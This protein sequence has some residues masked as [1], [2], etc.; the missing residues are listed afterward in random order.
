MKII[1]DCK[2]AIFEVG[3]Y[4]VILVATTVYSMLHGG[5]GMK[6][7]YMYPEVEDI[8]NK[9][10]YGDLR[11]LGTRITIPVN[12]GKEVSLLY[13]CNYPTSKQSY[14]D[15]EALEHCLMTANAEFKG[16]KVMCD[17]LGATKFNGND[18]KEKCLELIG[19][20]LTDVDLTVYD[21][22]QFSGTEE[23]RRAKK[24][25]ND[26]KKSDPDKFKRFNLTPEQLTVK[27]YARSSDADIK[28]EKRKRGE[29]GL[30]KLRIT[31][32]QYTTI[33]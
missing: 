33:N 28:T 17:V 9:Q 23:Y 26:L 11:R 13:C 7:R 10:P 18:N 19:K 32:N 16:K 27:L 30:D 8:N 1:T 31:F 3:K 25:L 5:L 21:Y 24:Y 14:L 6:I 12:D 2:D 22:E 4:D 29:I 20:C 15:L